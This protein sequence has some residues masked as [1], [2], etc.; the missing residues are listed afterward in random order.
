MY[1]DRPSAKHK[2]AISFFSILLKSV[3]ETQCAVLVEI[4]EFCDS[5]P[6]LIWIESVKFKKGLMSFWEN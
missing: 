4:N 1:R 2:N 5:G 6:A 3:K